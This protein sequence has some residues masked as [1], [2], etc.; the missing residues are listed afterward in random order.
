MGKM[1]KQ[2]KAVLFDVCDELTRYER[3]DVE[4]SQGYME[5]EFKPIPFAGDPDDLRFLLELEKHP[6]VD[7]VRVWVEKSAT[8]IIHTSE[9]RSSS[10]VTFAILF[11]GLGYHPLWQAMRETWTDE[12]KE[13]MEKG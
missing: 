4:E 5:I 8:H 6:A 9:A 7:E 1:G 2:Q 12:V 10:T 3:I 13:W 11:R